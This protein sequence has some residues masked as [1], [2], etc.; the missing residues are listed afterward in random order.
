LAVR[1]QEAGI[2]IAIDI[3]KKRTIPYNIYN[4]LIIKN[5]IFFGWC[6]METY[7][8]DEVGY[9]MFLIIYQALCYFSIPDRGVEKYDLL[10]YMTK[11]GHGGSVAVCKI[12]W[13]QL[14]MVSGSAENG[15]RRP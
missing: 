4:I 9:E 13:R 7:I 8:P 14:Q 15:R 2:H 12:T 3:S 6:R 1:Q 11:N 5:Y 10:A